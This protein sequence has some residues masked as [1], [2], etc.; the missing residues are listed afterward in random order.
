MK[1]N[2]YLLSGIIGLC[3]G[4]IIY[5]LWQKT[6]MQLDYHVIV[7]DYIKE[8]K[9]HNNTS[10]YYQSLDSLRSSLL[11]SAKQ[12]DELVLLDSTQQHL[13]K[14]LWLYLP[15]NT[16]LDCYKEHLNILKSSKLPILAISKH[17]TKN[18]YLNFRKEQQ[19][20]SNS[21]N[22]KNNNHLFSH[23]NTPFLLVSKKGRVIKLYVIDKLYP[24]GLSIFLQ[25]LEF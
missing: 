20:F 13:S 1:I 12:F 21:I 6:K 8:K 11:H 18:A 24:K 7:Q 14:K 25:Q 22:L 4:V 19:W 2:R 15:T 3:L 5:L 10:A 17:P 23:V 16:C 9:L